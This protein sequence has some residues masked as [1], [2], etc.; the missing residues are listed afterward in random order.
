MGI[1][2]KACESISPLIKERGIVYPI[3]YPKFLEQLVVFA[4]VALFLCP[5]SGPIITSQERT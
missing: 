3:V 1:I 4:Q 2:V 5:T